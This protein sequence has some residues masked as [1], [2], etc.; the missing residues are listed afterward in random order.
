MRSFA[1]FPPPQEE[2]W[3]LFLI[4][5]KAAKSAIDFGVMAL[6]TNGRIRF[7]KAWTYFIATCFPTYDKNFSTLS[8]TEQIDVLVS[9]AQHVR[10]RGVSRKKKCS[11]A[12][13]PSIATSHH[14]AFQ[15]EKIS[16]FITSVS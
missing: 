9:F 6:T 2:P 10:S 1:L 11:C 14:L 4:S 7:W 5:N 3:T 13:G 16:F 8:K 15:L 12:N